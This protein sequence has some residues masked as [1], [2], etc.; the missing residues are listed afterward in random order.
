MAAGCGWKVRRSTAS[1][2]SRAA[3]AGAAAV[4]LFAAGFAVGSSP[5]GAGPRSPAGPRFLLLLHETSSTA[6]TGLPEPVLVDEYRSWARTVSANG[7]VVTGEKLKHQPGQTLSGFFIIE[8]SSLEAARAI[9]GS[10]PHA[11]YGGRIE[12][13]EI[14][15]T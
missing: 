12:I 11:R 10:S 4:L 8:A 9:A 15:P 1:R 14:D 13:R 7:H 3:L 2:L 5:P 6:S